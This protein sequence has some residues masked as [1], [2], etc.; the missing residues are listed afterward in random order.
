MIVSS[1][2]FH[3]VPSHQEV[4][5]LTD[6]DNINTFSFTDSVYAFEDITNEPRDNT[7]DPFN[8]NNNRQDFKEKIVNAFNRNLPNSFKS[9]T[10]PVDTPA[11]LTLVRES[12]GQN[13]LPNTKSSGNRDGETILVVSDVAVGEDRS[14][15]EEQKV[16]DDF[17]DSASV[18]SHHESASVL[19]KTSDIRNSVHRAQGQLQP[20][21]QPDN[22]QMT[23]EVEEAD[24][25]KESRIVETLDSNKIIVD[26]LKES[27][28][29]NKQ[30]LW[31]SE[32]VSLLNDQ[33]NVLE[34]RTDPVKKQHQQRLPK[35]LHENSEI[36][37]KEFTFVDLPNLDKIDDFATVIEKNDT[38]GNV[39]RTVI[40]KNI[41]EAIQA[42]GVRNAPF[43][44]KTIKKTLD[45][46]T[47]IAPKIEKPSTENIQVLET[48]GLML[49]PA[50]NEIFIK[51]DY[52]NKLNDVVTK[53][54]KID[55]DSAE[56]IIE[57]NSDQF[58]ETLNNNENNVTIEENELFQT[59]INNDTNGNVQRTIIIKNTPEAL[60]MFGIENVPFLLSEEAESDSVD[61]V[62]TLNEQIDEVFNVEEESIS[63]ENDN[64]FVIHNNEEDFEDS[65]DDNNLKAQE[66]DDLVGLDSQTFNPLQKLRLNKIKADELQDFQ[67]EK[68]VEVESQTL[69]TLFYEDLSSHENMSER[70]LKKSLENKDI[71]N[72]FEFKSPEFD[73]TIQSVD[74][75]DIMNDIDID[76]F[77]LKGSDERMPK[78]FSE[79]ISSDIT[80]GINL[81][82]NSPLTS[83]KSDEEQM[84]GNI[85]NNGDII[86]SN[87][88]QDSF[89]QVNSPLVSS[90]FETIFVETE[91]PLVRQGE[92]LVYSEEFL[93]TEPLTEADLSL[94][95]GQELLVHSEHQTNKGIFPEQNSF[96][97][98]SVASE[99]QSDDTLIGSDNFVLRTPEPEIVIP[100]TLDHEQNN[101]FL[102]S[103][104]ISSFLS[105]N[106][107]PS[108]TDPADINDQNILKIEEDH[109]TDLSSHLH[110]INNNILTRAP[111][112][113]DDQNQNTGHKDK[114][115]L[116]KFN[117]QPKH[118]NFVRFPSEEESGNDFS[119]NEISTVDSQNIFQENINVIN[120]PN[121]PF[122]HNNI[123]HNIV[124]KSSNNNNFL[125]NPNQNTLIT[126]E[127]NHNQHAFISGDSN[128]DINI[129]KNII[130]NNH[131]EHTNI[132][133]SN[134]NIPEKIV[135]PVP[136]I[137]RSASGRIR[138][139]VTFQYG[140]EPMT[141]APPP[142][143]SPTPGPKPSLFKKPLDLPQRANKIKHFDRPR[144]TNVVE[145]YQQ[146]TVL[147]RVSGWF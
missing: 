120:S 131:N 5:G 51:E 71:Q 145:F 97:K 143:F 50:P 136:M 24:S 27:S 129:N 101:Q 42:F 58:K 140:F 48:S 95:P 54:K 76:L 94:S 99:G 124:F 89:E 69:K 2:N 37:N 78:V 39:R 107:S 103:S 67:I 6:V 86:S 130:H 12:S 138:I 82:E 80:S 110:S 40:I 123:K 106:K 1:D 60:K 61:S 96:A 30:I 108:G 19:P 38:E 135:T 15:E 118:S 112:H 141:R 109:P 65:N 72:T 13:I 22:H 121:K 85:E 142:L 137:F 10:E 114:N 133:I 52:D 81:F 62:N 36:K 127:I 20:R 21:H 111:P 16:T 93:D 59:F 26:H 70:E 3:N 79:L 47:R 88:I 33:D 92:F 18:N 7:F 116:S 75:N 29:T 4:S 25:K 44:S 113:H 132:H 98:H 115:I 31:R 102:S 53:T 125:N 43:E 28:L 63:E 56:I 66:N 17:A 119:N 35:Q 134:N 146:P 87:I 23:D 74:L 105:D 128:N 117:N 147:D 68:E 41:P 14:D 57:T 144:R 100:S 49:D 32:D 83:E 45:K 55:E 73:L 126:S 122:G 84:I 91:D 34:T 64:L 8:N 46:E 9:V 139:P 11:D 104:H 90:Q 77:N